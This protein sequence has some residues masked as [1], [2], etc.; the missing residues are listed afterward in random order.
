[1]VQPSKSWVYNA[2][3][4][5]VQSHDFK[6]FQTYGNLNLSHKIVLLPIKDRGLKEELIQE[7]AEKELTVKES[8]ERI[9]NLKGNNNGSNGLKKLPQIIQ[10]PHV[11]FSDDYSSFLDVKSLSEYHITT[12]DNIQKQIPQKMEEIEKERE[13]LSSYLNSYEELAK[14]INEVKDQ[15]SNERSA[16]PA[17]ESGEEVSPFPEKGKPGPTFAIQD[18]TKINL[19][20]IRNKF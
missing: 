7:I 11:L 3:N 17:L 5:V 19:L 10:K 9:A 2:V 6:G 1:L 20:K 16:R 4:L 18:A 14:K 12:L 8:K 13:R 15:K